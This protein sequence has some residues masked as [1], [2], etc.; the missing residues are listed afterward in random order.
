MPQSLKDDDDIQR[1]VKSLYCAEN[2]LRGT[3]MLTCRKTHFSSVSVACR[4]M[5]ANCGANTQ[6][7]V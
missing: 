7:L 4:C 2:K 3:F 5:L 6:R 1:Q